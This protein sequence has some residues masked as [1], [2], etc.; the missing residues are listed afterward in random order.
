MK[1]TGYGWVVLL[2]FVMTMP[3]VAADGKSPPVPFKQNSRTPID[4]TADT[5]EVLQEENK[6]IFTGHVVAIQGDVRLTSE[7]MV[8]HYRASENKDKKAG[9]RNSIRKI[10]VEQNVFLATPTETAS[11]ATGVYDVE[12]QIIQMD[13]N[14][15]LTKDKNTL[16]GDHLVYDFSTGKSTLTSGGGEAVSGKGKA[17][18]RVRALFIPENDDKMKKDETTPKPQP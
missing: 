16:K 4:I 17:K 1:Q 14:V 18:Q 9:D 15:V 6:A 11:G 12:R 2:A 7:K 13:S 10:E 3:A 8:V 5:L